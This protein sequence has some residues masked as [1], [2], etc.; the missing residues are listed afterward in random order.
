MSRIRY[1]QTRTNIAPEV[2]AYSDE[3]DDEHDND[4]KADAEGEVQPGFLLIDC[5]AV[6]NTRKNKK[7][8]VLEMTLRSHK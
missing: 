7:S 1:I 6:R 2:D 4:A 5:R 3:D 8:I